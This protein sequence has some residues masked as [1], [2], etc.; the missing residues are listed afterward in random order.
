MDG[1]D[2]RTPLLADSASQE[3][4]TEQAENGS[5][6]TA[7]VALRRLRHRVC[8][9]SMQAVTST[10][11]QFANSLRLE[12]LKVV[13]ND[14]VTSSTITQVEA[15]LSNAKL[16]GKMQEHVKN[17]AS[18][19]EVMDALLRVLNERQLK[20][21][22]QACTAS[23]I[24]E[25]LVPLLCMGLALRDDRVFGAA[26]AVTQGHLADWV[27]EGKRSFKVILNGPCE[28]NLVKGPFVPMDCTVHLNRET[29][30][31]LAKDGESIDFTDNHP[32]IEAQLHGRVR[33]VASVQSLS[34]KETAENSLGYWVS[35]KGKLEVNWF[36]RQILSV[37]NIDVAP[38]FSAAKL[39]EVFADLKSV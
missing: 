11:H 15:L 17:K 24:H 7:S 6:A 2:L 32:Y 18:P 23:R 28:I 5:S 25:T 8:R 19:A 34:L 3:V 1:V 35:M 39:W 33:K 22:L 21:Q 36:L 4:V 26:A 37:L 10:A 30:L 13:E 14:L 12:M 20:T 38:T 31:K 16:M 9:G 27:C 29:S